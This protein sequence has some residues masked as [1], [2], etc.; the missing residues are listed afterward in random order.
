M[1]QGLEYDNADCL[2]VEA[3][4]H[5]DCWPSFRS[6]RAKQ[7]MAVE[8]RVFLLQLKLDKAYILRGF[9]SEADTKVYG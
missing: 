2:V 6:S 3:V 1:I 8:I 7:S 9:D 5:L 4:L